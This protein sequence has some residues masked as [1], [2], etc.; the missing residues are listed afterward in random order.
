MI[1]GLP[2]VRG[3]YIANASMADLTWFRVGGAA[4]VDGR[5]TRPGLVRGI[6]GRFA[7]RGEQAAVEIAE[8]EHG[9]PVLAAGVGKEP[10]APARGE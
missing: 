4:D 1:D 9:Q 7:V 5:V 8:I 3:K 6:D 10:T 2:R